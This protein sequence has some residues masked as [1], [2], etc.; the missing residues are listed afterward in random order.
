MDANGDSQFTQD[1]T[2]AYGAGG[3]F[4]TDS[5]SAGVD[6]NDKPGILINASRNEDDGKKLF[7]GGLSWET[8]LKDLR[9]YFEKFGTV[10]D[11][12]LK[13]DPT[14][15]RSRGFGFVLYADLDSVQRVQ[16]EKGHSLHGRSIDP[17]VAMAR[18]G[19]EPMKKA[20]V[21]G[22]DPG[23]EESVIREYFGQYGTIEDIKFP[24]D[25][26]KNQ[27]RAFIFITYDTEESCD[28][29]CQQSKQTLASKTVDVKKAT[30]PEEAGG[31]GGRGRGGFRGGRGGRGR[32][33]YNQGWG[34][35]D[36]GYG[37]YGGYGYDQGYGYC[38][39][40]D[41]GYGYDYGGYGGGWSGYGGG[42]SSGGY[43]G[44]N[45]GGGCGAGQGRYK[46]KGGRGNG[47]NYH[48]YGR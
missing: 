34:G 3:E 30:P 11:C 41:Q 14:T 9:E 39:G 25:K 12:T 8:T 7:V 23:T 40:Y 48:P 24:F 15:G 36:Q 43:G 32:G 33:G 4:T 21:G 20:F 37:G 28:K 46:A 1:G 29:C 27:R 2:D 22:V 38:G 44:G 47:N 10:A 18:G 19:K 45:Q 5:T 42:Q 26:M 31:F 6:T 17:K 16:N 35:Y 13:T